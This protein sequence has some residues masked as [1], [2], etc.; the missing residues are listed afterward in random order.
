LRTFR[1][2]SLQ[3]LP[4]GISTRHGG[5]S[6]FP[7]ATLNMGVS[8]G[9][10]EENVLANRRT[11]VESLG[12][13]REDILVGRLSHG[14]AVSVF[15]RSK[16]EAYPMLRVPLQDGSQHT[17]WVFR[18]DAVVSNVPDMRFL[19]TFADCVPLVFF[20]S[21]RGAMGAAHAGWRGTALG[22]GPAVVRAMVEAFG[23]DPADLQ[24]G[25]GPSIGP[26]CYSVRREVLRAFRNNG[27]EPIAAERAGAWHL[28]LWATNEWQLSEVGVPMGSIEQAHLCTACHVADFYSHRAERGRT[29]RFALLAGCPPAS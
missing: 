27:F 6:P 18:S 14:N 16:Q 26:C 17:V 10:R 24:V 5:V 22:I 25:I 15:C 23:T 19:L 20:D 29:G 28:D 3:S 1:F 11:F 9:D 21:R 8:T 13:T 12:S 7:Y 2:S 4:H